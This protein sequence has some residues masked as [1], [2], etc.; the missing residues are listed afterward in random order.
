MSNEREHDYLLI[1]IFK[2]SNN[3]TVIAPF[4]LNFRSLICICDTTLLHVVSLQKAV[5]EQR[6]YLIFR[7]SHFCKELEAYA[8]VIDYLNKFI[9]LVSWNCSIF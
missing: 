4:C 8:T 3:P 1:E 5:F 7:I 9:P 6:G 2:S